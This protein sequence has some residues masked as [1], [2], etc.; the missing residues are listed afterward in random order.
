M[1]LPV[2]LAGTHRHVFELRHSPQCLPLPYLHSVPSIL[3][4]RKSALLARTIGMPSEIRTAP[5]HV[6]VRPVAKRHWLAA[7]RAQDI[8]A[9]ECEP[10]YFC[11]E[12][13]HPCFLRGTRDQCGPMG[14]RN[15]V[16]C[17]R[18]VWSN[19][20]DRCGPTGETSVVQRERLV[21]SNGRDR[22][23]PMGET[24]VIQWEKP[25]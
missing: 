13:R 23:G 12:Q 20:R 18:Q 2:L 22:C 9:V 19:G 10:L 5:V 1:N 16:Q 15:V 11:S 24:S 3:R 17:E 21:W 6:T 7:L 25:V 8:R 4:L 14:E